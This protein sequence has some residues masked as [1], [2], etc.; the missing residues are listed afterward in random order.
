[1]IHN[2][3]APQTAKGAPFKYLKFKNGNEWENNS[4][5]ELTGTT[6]TAVDT[7]LENI[8]NPNCNEESKDPIVI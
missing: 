6:N 8:N 7:S 1:L 4:S 5:T 3:S 2:E